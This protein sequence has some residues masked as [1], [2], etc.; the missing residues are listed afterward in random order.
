MV[1]TTDITVNVDE[2][3]H[4][5]VTLDRDDKIKMYVNGVLQNLTTTSGT[6]DLTPH[7]NSFLINTFPFRIG[8]YTYTDYGS[9]DQVTIYVQTTTSTGYALEINYLA[10]MCYYA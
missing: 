1:E 6:N 8:S 3:Y 9:Y 2:W 5:S 4:V 10:A 7:K